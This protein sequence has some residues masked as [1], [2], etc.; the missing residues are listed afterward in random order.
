MYK[1][2]HLP[3]NYFSPSLGRSRN[4]LESPAL[5]SLP[6]YGS[7]FFSRLLCSTRALGDAEGDRREVKT[8]S[9]L[10]MLWQSPF[11]PKNNLGWPP[12]GLSCT[13][14]EGGSLSLSHTHTKSSM[15]WRWGAPCSHCKSP[16]Q[17]I[18]QWQQNPPSSKKE[19]CLPAGRASITREY[20]I[21]PPPWALQENKEVM[22]ESLK[23]T[24]SCSRG[25]CWP[26][27]LRLNGRHLPLQQSS[28]RKIKQIT[29]VS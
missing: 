14:T 5:P 21:T 22:K 1:I 28:A 3:V 26:Q 24:R 17:Y 20:L 16:F 11:Q 23:S 25:V 15:G 6:L 9:T 2:M 10:L 7:G 12:A 18:F 19:V 27:K 8:C 29:C 4:F 13:C